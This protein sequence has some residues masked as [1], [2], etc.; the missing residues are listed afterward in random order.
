MSKVN[1]GFQVT[2]D[3]QYDGSSSRF[4]PEHGDGTLEVPQ[5]VWYKHA[6]LR[7]LYPMMP[8]LFLGSTINGYDGSLL[9][10]LQTMTP[11]QDCELHLNIINKQ[12]D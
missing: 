7:K 10:G 2:T 1:D 4:S 3:P 5:V 6:G 9:N 12:L 8:I 11:W